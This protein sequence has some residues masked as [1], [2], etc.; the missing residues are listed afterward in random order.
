MA[1]HYQYKYLNLKYI[2]Q[3]NW[4][5]EVQMIHGKVSV[6]NSGRERPEIRLAFGIHLL[7]FDSVTLLSYFYENIKA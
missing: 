1:C 5:H 3:W 7:L 2:N 4:K 6:Q